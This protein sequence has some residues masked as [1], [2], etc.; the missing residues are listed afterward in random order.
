MGLTMLKGKGVRMAFSTGEGGE[1]NRAL[2]NA[3]K[4]IVF[5]FFLFFFLFYYFYELGALEDEFGQ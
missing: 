1:V 2:E 3:D 5:S 4:R